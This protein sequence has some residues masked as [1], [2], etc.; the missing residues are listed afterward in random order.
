MID[1]IQRLIESQYSIMEVWLEERIEDITLFPC[2]SECG[3]F[4]FTDISANG[5][6]KIF[7]GSYEDMYV[8]GHYDISEDPQ[9][10]I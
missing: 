2:I 7:D 8:I 9:A 6:I 3:N 4:H 1:D 10:W 5:M